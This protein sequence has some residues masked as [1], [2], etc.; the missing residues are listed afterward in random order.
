VFFS[1]ILKTYCFLKALCIHYVIPHTPLF[2]RY[3][4]QQA[5]N[6]VNDEETNTTSHEI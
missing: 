6:A 2:R 5:K 1:Y 4:V 3:V